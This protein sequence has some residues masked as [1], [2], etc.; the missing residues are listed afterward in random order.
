MAASLQVQLSQHNL[1]TTTKQV[2]F[3]GT[4]MCCE[5]KTMIGRRNVWSMKWKVPDQEV[6]YQRGLRERC[7]KT[8]R[9]VN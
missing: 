6:G 5:K 4:G 3:D 1:G 8:V 2:S 9:R 7:K